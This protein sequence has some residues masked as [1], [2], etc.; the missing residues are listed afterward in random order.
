M[1]LQAHH[2]AWPIRWFRGAFADAEAHADAGI[3][4]YD[5]VRHA[6]Q[7]FL[8][9]GDDP[10]V[11]ALSI[12]AVLQWL[13]GRPTQGLRSEHEAVDLGRRLKHVPSLAHALWFVCQGQIA[14]GDA[15]AVVETAEELLALSEENGL[16]QTRAAA[17]VYLGWAMGQTKDVAHGV[18]R[19]E[20][21]ISA[22]N[23]LGIRSNLCL[24]ICLLGETYFVGGRYEEAMEQ[25]E[26][27]IATSS[28]VGDSWCLP[29]VHMIRA[30][31]LEK[32]FRNPDA[33]E[34]SLREAID[35]AVLQCARGPE[36]RA[37]TSLARLWRDQGRRAEVHDLLAPV[38]GWFTEGFDTLDLKEA[39]ALLLVAELAD[40]PK[41]SP[42]RGS[43]A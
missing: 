29:R 41:K 42:G 24:S 38:Y 1:L 20:E 28:H 37:A 18:Q 12:K 19:L 15:V 35:V 16:P 5:V 32:G 39:K 14:R 36:L 33:A 27:A 6:R 7:R 40:R 8:Y 31:L 25:V 21:G 4:L 9:L 22:W 26:L 43:G 30:R 17:L 2:C 23:H 11:C 34:A 3:R 13:L 10:A